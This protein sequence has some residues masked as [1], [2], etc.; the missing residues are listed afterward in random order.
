M[1]TLHGRPVVELRPVA[2]VVPPLRMADIAWLASHR[3][4]KASSE[5]AGSFVSSMRDDE[6][7]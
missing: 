1:I 6:E 3:V 7:R 2:P 4:G 5:D